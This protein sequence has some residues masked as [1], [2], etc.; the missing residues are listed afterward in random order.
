MQFPVNI[1]KLLP[2]N[3][4]SSLIIFNNGNCASLAYALDNRKSYEGK[5]LVKESETIIDTAVYTIQNTDYIC[6][7]IK[8]SKDSYDI[9]TCPLREE[10]GDM[11]KSKLSRIK[12]ERNEDAYVVGELVSNHNLSV[13]FLCKYNSFH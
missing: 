4:Q 9:L 7:V 11:E 10:L 1:L 12:V 5:F 2:R 6:Y 13:Y 3:E 8:N